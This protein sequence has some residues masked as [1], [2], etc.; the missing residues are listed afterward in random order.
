MNIDCILIASN[1]YKQL[2]RKEDTSQI[3]KVQFDVRR[4]NVNFRI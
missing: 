2:R 1:F 3:C 4:I